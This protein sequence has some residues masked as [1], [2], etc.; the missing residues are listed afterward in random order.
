MQQLED[1]F[2][3]SAERGEP[4]DDWVAPGPP[5]EESESESEE[6]SDDDEEAEVE[7]AR[8]SL[9]RCLEQPRWKM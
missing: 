1:D 6:E 4:P 3:S 7:H 8:A 5:Q 2:Q 9:Q